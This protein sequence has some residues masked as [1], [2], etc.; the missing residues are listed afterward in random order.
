VCF[1]FCTQNSQ[2]TL[3][4]MRLRCRRHRRLLLLLLL[5]CRTYDEEDSAADDGLSWQRNVT[6]WYYSTFVHHALAFLSLDRECTGSLRRNNRAGF[7]WWEAWAYGL[8]SSN[9]VVTE[10]CLSKIVF[11][12]SL[13]FMVFVLHSFTSILLFSLSGSIRIVLMFFISRF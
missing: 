4:W 3:L 9:L 10:F 8:W 6:L 1:A 7:S 5:L 13:V 11:F 12:I 2:R